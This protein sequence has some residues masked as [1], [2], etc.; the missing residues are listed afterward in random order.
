MSHGGSSLCFTAGTRKGIF[1]ILLQPVMSASVL[2]SVL[3][4]P[5]AALLAQDLVE[6]AGDAAQT[7]TASPATA[8][9]TQK[10]T[11][12]AAASD[13]KEA[14]I[15][16]NLLVFDPVP[17]AIQPAAA[18]S[19]PGQ[20]PATVA[21]E[22]AT[23]PRGNPLPVQNL[24]QTYA[25]PVSA[26]PASDTA[27]DGV[28]RY[29]AQ[30]KE[31][32][33]KGNAYD[34]ELTETLLGLAA[35]YEN[36]GEY[37][38]ALPLYERA[39][40]IT[41]VNHGLFSLDQVP[42]VQRVIANDIARGDLLSADQQQDYLFYL[43]RRIHGDN[44]PALLT[45]MLDYA[46]WNVYAFRARMLSPP[47]VTVEELT[48]ATPSTTK[49]PPPVEDIFA[50]RIEKLITAQIAYENIINLIM[51]HFGTTDPRLP[52]A[53]RALAVTNYLY[54]TQVI[55]SDGGIEMTNGYYSPDFPRLS[56]GG[57]SEGREALERRVQYLEQNGTASREEI[58]RAKM[59]LGDW[60]ITSR[61][62]MNAVELYDQV[63]ADY[64]ASGASQTEIDALFHPL[65]PVSIPTFVMNPYTRA[66]LSIPADAAIQYRGYVDVEF[67]IGRYGQTSMPRELARSQDVD[68]KVVEVLMRNIRRDQFRPRYQD[69][70]AIEED[71]VQIRY[72]YSY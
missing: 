37:A 63:F 10:G 1:R 16:F 49:E 53:E 55:A 35:S 60:L 27:L 25:N 42:I 67:S 38:N 21:I 39:S 20:A 71:R 43:N 41:R 68:D 31:I 51:A 40:H 26:I 13:K 12:N 8:K 56:G 23:L 65:L 15:N 9:E 48:D 36:V 22:L 34:L 17:L 4:L 70:H 58:T 30:L 11:Q 32:E 3:G 54:A 2:A 6:N 5:S 59:E 64:V 61:K 45:A 50:F 19:T 47:V 62:R 57:F 69:G 29:E 7:A 44:N 66:S 33:Q 18:E 72:Y 24:M 46:E 28:V 52:A 14:E